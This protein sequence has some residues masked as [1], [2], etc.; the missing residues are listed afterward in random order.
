[1]KADVRLDH[2]LLAVE[3]EHDV[4]AMLE[5]TVPQGN[6]TERAP[7]H[8]ALVIDRSGSMHGGRLD[9]A[10]DAVRYLAQRLQTTD[11]LAVITYDD[12]VEL[13][14]ALGPIA[15]NSLLEAQINAIQTGGSTNLSGGW[16][17]GI[18]EVGRAAG[19]GIRR[20]L[21][22]TDGHANVGIIEPAALIGIAKGSKSLCSTT[23]IG[24]GEG[25]DEDLLA[26]IADAADGATYYAETVEDAPAIF[27]EE[28][29]GLASIMAQNLS[30]E[31]RPTDDVKVLGVLNDYPIVDVPGGMQLQIGDVFGGETR[32]IIL[33]LHIPQV[34]ALGVA[35]VCDLVVRYVTTQ[36]PIAQHELIVPV[37]VNLVSADEAAAASVDHEVTEHV[38]LL[39]AARARRDARDAA[40][41]GDYGT[42]RSI[43]HCAA[44]SLRAAAPSAAIGDE[45]LAEAEALEVHAAAMEA[46]IYDV[47]ASKRL[48]YEARRS[49]R[50]RKP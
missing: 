48:H 28:F 16:L 42:A 17:K 31:I 9:A 15:D 3:G 45:L 21:L 1:M 38:T 30:V 19:E 47:T 49:S 10:K 11:Q 20:V 26:T 25:F 44:T 6:V 35:R 46:D 27:T 22:L 41:R 12:Q 2:Q 4:H 18:E 36:A 29:D 33:Q 32:R 5:I 24:F 40:D 13:V 39:T 43:I 7:L 50:G 8:L 23:T 34:A 37:T 14:R